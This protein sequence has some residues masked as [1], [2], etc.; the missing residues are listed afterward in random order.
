MAEGAKLLVFPE[1]GAMEL[2]SLAGREIAA[3]LH[4]SLDAVSDYQSLQS[5]VHAALANKHNV[6][7]VAASLPC[8]H[9][10]GRA[11]NVARIFAPGG[12]SGEYH[13]LMPTP[14]EREQWHISSGPAEGLTVFDLGFA[15][16]GLVICY[17]I[18]F[19]LIG[20]ALAEAGAEIILA[21]SN[22]ELEHGY[23][24]VRTG[25]MARALENQVYT[26]HSPTVGPAE[27]CEA[28]D[29]NAGSAGV[30]AP[31]DNG[32]TAGGVV[33]LGEMNK[34]QWVFADVDLDLMA[35]LRTNGRVQTYR[36]WT[37]QP[38]AGPLPKAKLVSLA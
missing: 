36:H 17:D 8:R 2:A 12:K 23:W 31:S 15:K 13:K 29:T 26:V 21:P 28:A 6:A 18:E 37:E 32:F 9:A 7:I 34:A 38:G 10:D 25:C 4:K 22:T 30:F 11:T 20:R 27:W 3:D 19:P 1:Y 33:A 24:R 5:E 35:G 14:F 16:V